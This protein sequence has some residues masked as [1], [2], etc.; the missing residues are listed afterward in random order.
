MIT[1]FCHTNKAF[2]SSSLNWPRGD[3]EYNITLCDFSLI[4]VHNIKEFA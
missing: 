2:F 3:N 1:G 4:N